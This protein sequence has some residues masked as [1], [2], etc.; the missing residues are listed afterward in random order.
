MEVSMTRQ[1]PERPN[2][3]HLR[4]EAK[5]LQ[6]SLSIKLSEAQLTL[7]R[8]YGFASWPKL[9]RFVEGSPNRHAAFFA[10]VRAG[11]RATAAT[12]LKEDAT[13]VF[14][15]HPN[16]FDA[17]ALNLAATRNDIPLID[18]LLDHGADPNAK[19]TWWA[20]GFCPLDFA[21][22]VTS[23]HLLKRGA[24]LTAHAAARLG[25]AKELSE[26]LKRNPEVVH[27][28]GGDGQMPLHFAKTPEI[29]DLLL[30]AGADI[31]ARDIDHEGT[32][33]QHAILNAPVLE[34][35]IDRGAKQDVF[36]AVIRE[37]VEA[38]NQFLDED[39]EALERQTGEPGNPQVPVAPGAHI[40]TYSLGFSRPDQ[41]ATRFAKDRSYQVL[42][43]RATPR[44]RFL[45]SLWRGD[46]EVAR[47]YAFELHKE[48]MKML[49]QAAWERRTDAVKLM[50]ELG[51]DVNTRGLD[52]S[53]AIDRAAF[54]G[55][56]DVIEAI[57][58][59][60][61]DLTVRNVYGGTPL[62]ACLFGSVHGWRKDGNYPRSV[63]LLLNAGS[64]APETEEGKARLQ[65]LLG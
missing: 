58:P 4:N 36:M 24:H 63:R 21:D 42:F 35:L 27:E 15:R 52:E 39:A 48:D 62:G 47:T 17:P 2:L 54:H 61:P 60:E 11:D 32:P 34:R 1:L 20:G 65:A 53:T 59:Y 43:G 8:E 26:I 14:A 56:D 23:N 25:M 6:R 12:L 51:F 55:F 44:Q 5:E 37:D 46:S 10:A 38:L 49:P 18:L 9:K 16:S 64:P 22:E 7:A 33:A 29:V 19:S 57:L 41:V 13:L 3:E 30:D 40:Y 50:L 45:V 28:R 31:E